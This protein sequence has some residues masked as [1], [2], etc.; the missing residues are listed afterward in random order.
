MST[1]CQPILSPYTERRKR[2]A[3]NITRKKCMLEEKTQNLAERDSGLYYTLEEWVQEFLH[4]K[5]TFYSGSE[6]DDDDNDDENY[7]ENMEAAVRRF[8]S[9]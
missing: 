9:K 2:E 7:K 1:G 3:S 4:D 8:S 6:S 5:G